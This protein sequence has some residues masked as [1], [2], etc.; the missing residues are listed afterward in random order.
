MH[1]WFPFWLVDQLPAIA[2]L[3]GWA[4]VAVALRSWVSV[5]VAAVA[6]WVGFGLWTDGAI[7]WGGGMP[8]PSAELAWAW[9][10][11]VAGLWWGGEARALSVRSAVPLVL[12]LGGPWGM[13]AGVVL[14][15]RGVTAPGPG[16]RRSTAAV[17]A[18][19]LAIA[20]DGPWGGTAWGTAMSLGLSMDGASAAVSWAI[21]GA[22]AVGWAAVVIRP[23]TGRLRLFEGDVDPRPTGAG[24]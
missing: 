5:G 21:A 11:L 14:T 20:L 6:L 9:P 24:G 17:V 2:H 19:A 13:A 3:L 15:A 8:G 4:A 23:R 10:V 12:A 18:L 7:V 16:A 1:P 22:V